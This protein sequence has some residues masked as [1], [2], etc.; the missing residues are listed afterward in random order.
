M[1]LSQFFTFLDL[2]HNDFHPVVNFL[3][4]SHNLLRNKSFI[5]FKHELILKNLWG[6][7]PSKQ[8]NVLASYEI[9]TTCRHRPLSKN[10]HGHEVT[11][12]EC[13]EPKY[14]SVSCLPPASTS[15][16]HDF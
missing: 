8:K 9:S 15:L 6:F 16:T 13:R 10:T 14:L 5:F 1:V 3:M 11:G 4:T 7:F 2:R 12:I